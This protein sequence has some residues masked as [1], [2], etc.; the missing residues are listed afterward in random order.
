V[1]PLVNDLVVAVQL[2]DRRKSEVV[3]KYQGHTESVN[4][5]C[6][7]PRTPGWPELMASCSSD[8]TVRVWYVVAATV[9][10]NVEVPDVGAFTSIAGDG[11]GGYAKCTP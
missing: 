7:L 3:K 9:A 6:F 4:G 8:C 11:I 2:W 10:A 1:T 5:C